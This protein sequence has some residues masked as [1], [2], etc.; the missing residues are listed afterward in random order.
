MSTLA[1]RERRQVGDIHCE[2]LS[3]SRLDQQF[4]DVAN[5]R[6]PLHQHRYELSRSH[7]TD[8]AGCESGAGRPPPRQ[9]ISETK[10]PIFAKLTLPS[11]QLL[12]VSPVKHAGGHSFKPF[13]RRSNTCEPF[14]FFFSE[15]AV[16]AWNALLYL[17][18]LLHRLSTVG[19]RAFAVHGPR[20]WNSLP[21]D[22][23]A[24]Q[25]YESFRQ[26]LKTGL[27]SRY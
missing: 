19:R 4:I 16:N 25:D 6:T 12:R 24:Q 2:R 21:D 9:H 13:K 10:R 27:F 17:G 5:S 15:R 23:R 7:C 3:R 11:S 14:S 26:G 22:L 1:N 8:C 20:V 18:G